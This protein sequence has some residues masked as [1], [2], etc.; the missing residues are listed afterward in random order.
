M[1]AVLHEIDAGVGVP[2]TGR[3]LRLDPGYD[4]VCLARIA[5]SED[6]AF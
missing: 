6:V 2:F 5:S 1:S 4:P 3:K